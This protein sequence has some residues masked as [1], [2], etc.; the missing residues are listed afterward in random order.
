M[1]KVIQYA[2]LQ[3]Y[4]EARVIHA[5]IIVSSIELLVSILL[6]IVTCLVA[7]FVTA[8]HLYS[9]DN[10]VILFERLQLQLFGR[11]WVPPLGVRNS[12]HIF[13]ATSFRSLPIIRINS[14][15]PNH[16]DRT[17]PVRLVTEAV[18]PGRSATSFGTKKGAGYRNPNP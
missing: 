11:A 9:Y 12:L 13:G 6:Q 2:M 7:D 17:N 5:R 3:K 16:H 8:T 10:A 18:K 15:S 1:T 14:L 4:P